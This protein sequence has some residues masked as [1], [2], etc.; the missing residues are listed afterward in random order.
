MSNDPKRSSMFI[1][2]E[3]QAPAAQGPSPD[4]QW[5]WSCLPVFLVMGSLL[6]YR[7]IEM[8]RVRKE[9]E[10]TLKSIEKI[11]KGV[12]GLKDRYPSPEESVRSLRAAVQGEFRFR[13]VQ[14]MAIKEPDV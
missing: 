3:T 11:N 2:A 9:A 1:P 12:E 7:I 6:V 10:I 8:E 4:W 14:V 13:S 5:L